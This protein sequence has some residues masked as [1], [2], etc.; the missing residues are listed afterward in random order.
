MN[1]NEIAREL[2]NYV[3]DSFALLAYLQGKPG[4]E[5]VKAILEQPQPTTFLSVINLSEVLYIFE[6]E[7]GLEQARK[8]LGVIQ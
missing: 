5:R 7:Q 2:N 1:A 6:R 3:L 4:K 8:A